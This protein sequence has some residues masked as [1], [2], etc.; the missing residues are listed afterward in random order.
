MRFDTQLL[1]THFGDP[2]NKPI[3]LTLI[4]HTERETSK[5]TNHGLFESLMKH[6]ICEYET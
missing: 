6:D 4:P 3:N 5:V 2:Y 1:Q